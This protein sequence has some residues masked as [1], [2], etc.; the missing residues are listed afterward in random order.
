LTTVEWVA[1]QITEAFPWEE[2]PS[3]MIRDRDRIYG[4]IVTRRLRAMGIRDKPIAP[5]LP[6]Q[7]GFAE[8][9]IGSIRRECLD[10]IMVF[11][12]AHPLRVLR[13]Y[14]PS[15]QRQ[16]TSITG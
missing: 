13:P 15:Q 1:R 12:E 4:G 10:H 9:L 2:V 6:W 11:G 7:N 16:S 3:Y 5:A 14:A 8:R